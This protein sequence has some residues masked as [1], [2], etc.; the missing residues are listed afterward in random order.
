MF[1][2]SWKY[3]KDYFTCFVD[4]EKVCDRLYNFGEFYKGMALMVR[5]LLYALKSFYGAD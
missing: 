3:G 5:Q 1:E 2:K 4:L